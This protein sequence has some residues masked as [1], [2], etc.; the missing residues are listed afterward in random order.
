MDLDA[1]E[2]KGRNRTNG[3]GVATLVDNN[4]VKSRE[5]TL[6]SN[7]GKKQQLNV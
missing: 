7:I 6:M 4:R 1:M 2:M 5:E 3:A